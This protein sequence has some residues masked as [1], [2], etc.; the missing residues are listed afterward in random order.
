MVVHERLQSLSVLV[1]FYQAQKPIL[2]ESDLPTLTEVFPSS[3]DI[4]L[5]FCLLL[6]LMRLLLRGGRMIA[7]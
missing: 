3:S 7:L 2:Q 6:W 4:L 5:A 1:P